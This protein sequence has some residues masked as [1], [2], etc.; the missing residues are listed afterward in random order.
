MAFTNED[1]LNVLESLERYA[2]SLTNYNEHDAK[3]L[4]QETVLALTTK[5]A[6]FKRD[7]LATPKTWALTVMRN[8]FINSYRSKKKSRIDFI[9]DIKPQHGRDNTAFSSMKQEQLKKTAEYL[10]QKIWDWN[11]DYAQVIK[12]LGQG[13]KYKDIA[14]RMGIPIGTVKARIHNIREEMQNTYY[15]MYEDVLSNFE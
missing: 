13:V 7:S 2:L 15:K 10:M 8:L 9:E 1:L 11:P 5:A 14:E 6:M 4:V 12:L 3:D